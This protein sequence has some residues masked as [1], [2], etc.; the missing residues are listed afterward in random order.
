MASVVN[1]ADIEQKLGYTPGH[2]REANERV[3]KARNAE[4]VGGT[5]AFAYH[6][7]AYE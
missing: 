2:W 7:S 6:C 5:I 1:D 3:T 4:A